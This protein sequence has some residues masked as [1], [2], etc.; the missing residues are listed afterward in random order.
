MVFILSKFLS[1]YKLS[2]KN[3]SSVYFLFLF[4]LTETIFLK[5][6]LTG[7]L[8]LLCRCIVCLKIYYSLSIP[9]RFS[10]NE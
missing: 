4:F 10:W 2:E 5:K 1:I 8:C 3:E 9:T 6:N 7:F